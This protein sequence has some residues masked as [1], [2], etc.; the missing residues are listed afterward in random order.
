VGARS[1][2]RTAARLAW[3]AAVL[4]LGW[5]VGWARWTSFAED[6]EKM[7]AAVVLP[8]EDDRRVRRVELADELRGVGRARAAGHDGGWRWDPSPAFSQSEII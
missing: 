7:D 1:A 5:T 4:G 2:G 6:G 8:L 3:Y